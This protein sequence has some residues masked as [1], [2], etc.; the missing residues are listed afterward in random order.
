MS[1]SPVILHATTVAVEGRAVLIIG[2]SGAGKSSLALHLLA[3]GADLVAD[4]R[5]EVRRHNDQIIASVPGAIA[6]KIEARG[7]GILEV[8]A[9]GST[10]VALVVDLGQRETLRLPDLHRHSIMGVALPCLHN[11][12]TAHFPSALLLYMKHK[13]GA[14]H[15]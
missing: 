9:G 5:T 8:P 14:S 12:E 3:L 7:F 1:H 11:P 15:S 13:K 2:P 4:D 6:G 10:P